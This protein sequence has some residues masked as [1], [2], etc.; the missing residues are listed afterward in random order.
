MCN[1][2]CVQLATCVHPLVPTW[3]V[4]ISAGGGWCHCMHS[5]GCHVFGSMQL[6]GTQQSG[7]VWFGRVPCNQ[8]PQASQPHAAHIGAASKGA[9]AE[10]LSTAQL[11]QQQQEAKW[12][13]LIGIR[14]LAPCVH[15]NQQ[16]ASGFHDSHD[17]HDSR[18]PI[19]VV[20]LAIC[21]CCLSWHSD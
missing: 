12:P 21:V 15:L 11:A 13:K 1:L 14:L 20:A 3:M 6:L 10:L 18:K 2:L 4:Q 7:D 19:L 8:V 5:T 17:S 16:G 9:Q